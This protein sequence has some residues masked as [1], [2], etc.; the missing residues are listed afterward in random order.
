M[1]VTII[2]RGRGL[3]YRS[4]RGVARVVNSRREFSSIEA[5]DIVVLFRPDSE[6]VL[7]LDRIKGIISRSGGTTSHLAV[8]AMEWDIPYIIMSEEVEPVTNGEVIVLNPIEG[9][10]GRFSS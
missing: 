10:V 8:I 3:G 2:G 4:V 7:C 6:L 5:G 1:S 9:T